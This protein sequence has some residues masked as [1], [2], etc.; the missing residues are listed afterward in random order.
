VPDVIAAFSAVSEQIDSRSNHGVTSDDALRILRPGLVRLGFEIEASKTRV[1]KIWRPVLFGEGGR[2][3]V[4][5]EVDGFHP[6]HG[7]V[8]EIEAGRALPG[9]PIIETSFAR[10]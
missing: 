8:L 3:L 1:D 5:Y 10:A 2:P 7:I 9:T 6:Q 4:A